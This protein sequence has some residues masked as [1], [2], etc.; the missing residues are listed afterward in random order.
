MEEKRD[1]TFQIR[2]GYFAIAILFHLFVIIF[3]LF[4]QTGRRDKFYSALLGTAI[5]LLLGLLYYLATGNLR[6]SI[7]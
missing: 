4:A 3:T 2:W 6:P 7:R 1:N 5:N